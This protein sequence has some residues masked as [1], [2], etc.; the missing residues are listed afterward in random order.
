MVVGDWPPFLM[1]VA[2]TIHSGQLTA[3]GRIAHFWSLGAIIDFLWPLLG[4]LHKCTRTLNVQIQISHISFSRGSDSGAKVAK[5]GW[6]RKGRSGF[7]DI[8]FLG[9]KHIWPWWADTREPFSSHFYLK[10]ELLSWQMMAETVRIS[11]AA[12]FK[13]CQSNANTRQWW[14]SACTN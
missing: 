1:F 14:C 13:G 7:G 11:Y 12:F 5:A 4:V 9:D 10:S 8:S 6:D 3:S 2:S